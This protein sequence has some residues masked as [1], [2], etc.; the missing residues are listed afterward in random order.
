MVLRKVNLQLRLN[1]YKSGHLIEVVLPCR[2][3]GHNS[4]HELTRRDEDYK[5]VDGPDPVSVKNHFRVCGRVL[6]H[7]FLLNISWKEKYFTSS[8]K[9]TAVSAKDYEIISLQTELLSSSK[10]TTVL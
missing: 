3:K 4:G 9:Q 6:F 2:P 10:Q 5:E 7:R 8:A 1:L